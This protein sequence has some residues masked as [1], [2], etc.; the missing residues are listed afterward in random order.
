[1]VGVT[2]HLS[3]WFAMGDEPTVWTILPL[4]RTQ[5]AGRHLT[6]CTIEIA[7]NTSEERAGVAHR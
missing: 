5:E 1:M 7:N 6:K 2:S 3:V 4:L